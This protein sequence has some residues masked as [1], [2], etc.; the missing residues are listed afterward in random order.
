MTEP[1]SFSVLH[2]RQRPGAIDAS[3]GYRIRF[4]RLSLGMSQERLGEAV[5]V[6]LQEIA[7]FESGINRVG[8]CRLWDISIVLDVSISFFFQ[9]TPPGVPCKIDEKASPRDSRQPDA[10]VALAG[11]APGRPKSLDLLEAYNN[12]ADP[13]MRRNVL[14]LVQSMCSAR[15]Q[16]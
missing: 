4:R 6:T 9:D 11:E 15:P 16:V 5:G 2:T 12:V 13:V 8:A 3:I 10:P 14:I 1:Q 7:K